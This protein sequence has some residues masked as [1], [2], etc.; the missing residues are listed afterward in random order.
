[1]NYLFIQLQKSLTHLDSHNSLL[2]AYGNRSQIHKTLKQLK[3]IKI[4]KT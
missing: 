1:M 2:K 4:I 3:I